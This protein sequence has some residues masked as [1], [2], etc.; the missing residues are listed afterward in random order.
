[1]VFWPN[2]VGDDMPDQDQSMEPTQGAPVNLLKVRD[3]HHPICF[4]AKDDGT[5]E[6]CE[7]AD[8]SWLSDGQ[9]IKLKDIRKTV[10]DGIVPI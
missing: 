8:V 5:F 9:E 7:V 10:A 1:M 4:R 3:D 6:L 2:W